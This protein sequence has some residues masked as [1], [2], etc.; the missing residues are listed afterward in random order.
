[1]TMTVK[2]IINQVSTA[3]VEYSKVDLKH[4]LFAAMEN[5][6]YG[7]VIHSADE[8]AGK[9]FLT[10]SAVHKLNKD[11][12]MDALLPYIRHEE[13][14]QARQELSDTKYRQGILKRDWDYSRDDRMPLP[15]ALLALERGLATIIRSSEIECDKIGKLIAASSAI[16]MGEEIRR[17]G[18][19]VF[20]H[21]ALASYGHQL[22]SRIKTW[23]EAKGDDRM[24]KDEVLGYFIDVR[25]DAIAHVT[26]DINF[27]S[28]DAMSRVRLMEEFR[29]SQ[30]WSRIA[31]QVCKAFE[32]DMERD[33]TDHNL[34]GEKLDTWHSSV[35]LS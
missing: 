13:D 16:H 21:G 6:E 20:Y 11:G 32:K 10:K 17:H 12:L 4:A 14:V 30:K 35:N 31:S 18:S 15:H 1:M 7:G 3:L 25:N 34:S 19:E 22:R 33:P 23:L 28:S 2:N 8:D 29:A 5:W 27:G 9:C 26:S 24:T